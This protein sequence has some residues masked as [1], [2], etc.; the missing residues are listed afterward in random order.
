MSGQMRWMYACSCT[1][2]IRKD[3]QFSVG[4]SAGQPNSL[5]W[6]LLVQKGS[7]EGSNGE[8]EEK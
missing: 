4:N 2:A 5:F 1:F 6:G 8:T 7:G 3:L